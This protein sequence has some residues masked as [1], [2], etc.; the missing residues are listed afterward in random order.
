MVVDR[1]SRIRRGAPL[2]LLERGTARAQV[3]SAAAAVASAERDLEAADTLYKAGAVSERDYTQARTAL[4]AARAQLV[5]ARETLR[6]N[7][8]ESPITGVV[9][10]RVVSSGEAIRV[11]DRLFTVVDSDTLE[12][13]GQVGPDEIGSVH[14]GD[15]AVLRLESY[16]DRR[17]EGRVARIEPVANVETRQVGVYVH[18]PNR[19]HELVAG[20]FATGTILSRDDTAGGPVLAI[21]TSAVLEQQGAAIVFAIEQDTLN[22]RQVALGRATRPPVW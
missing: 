22:R 6:R 8:I 21:P 12:L 17:I 11:G 19:A 13:A 2:A 20:L 16:P 18:V 7:T 10:D 9:S 3:A 1:G 15:R 4:D 5:Q 14:I